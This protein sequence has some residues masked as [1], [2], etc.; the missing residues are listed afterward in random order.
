MQNHLAEAGIGTLIHYPIP[1]HLQKCYA[2]EK[3]NMPPLS[4]PVSEC[5]AKEELSIPI[6][7]TIAQAEAAAIVK[8]VNEFK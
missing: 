5:L 2:T 8:A 6:G 1:P 4:L 3:W 7:P